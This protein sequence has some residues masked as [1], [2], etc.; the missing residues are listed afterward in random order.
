MNRNPKTLVLPEFS[1]REDI[2]LPVGVFDD[3]TGDPVDM[4]AL[5]WTFQFEIRR[6]GPHGSGDDY[7]PWYDGSW[8]TPIITAA[9]GSGITIVAVGQLLIWITEPNVKKLRHRTY[10]AALV[11]TDGSRT[12]QI[13]KATLPIA[14]GGVTQ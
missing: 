9:L 4:A 5:G 13:F 14:Y 12:F 8:P 10:S 2:Y 7:G 11:A 3:D 1:N 6:T